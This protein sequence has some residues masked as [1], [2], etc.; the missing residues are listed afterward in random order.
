MSS[1]QWTPPPPQS[2][3]QHTA[4]AA[5]SIRPPRV[6]CSTCKC[7]NHSTEFCISPGGKLAGKTIEEA[8]AAQAAH[9]VT[10]A[11]QH[12]GTPNPLRRLDSR[13]ISHNMPSSAIMSLPLL[14]EKR[15]LMTESYMLLSTPRQPFSPLQ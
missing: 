1:Q 12:V 9:R 3:T 2:L 13:P 6:P 4:L 8:H 5:N 14:P 15:S 11:A 10:V 7:L